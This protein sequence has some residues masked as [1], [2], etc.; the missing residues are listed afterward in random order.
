MQDREGKPGWIT[1]ISNSSLTLPVG[2]GA[3]P[4]LIVNYLKSYEGMGTA[5]LTLNRKSVSLTGL[6]DK[7]M[8]TTVSFVSQAYANIHQGDAGNDNNYGAIGFGV[9]PHSFHNLTLTFYENGTEGKFKLI[10]VITC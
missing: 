10:E 2:F 8:S 3:V 9:K 5:V 6:W 7:N 1:T 4:I